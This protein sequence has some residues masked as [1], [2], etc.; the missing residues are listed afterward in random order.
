MIFAEKH[1]TTFLLKGF[2]G[3]RITYDPNIINDWTAIDAV[4]TWVCGVIVP[5]GLVIFQKRLTE[6]ENR[7]SASNLALLEELKEFKIKYEPILSSLTSGEVVMNAGNASFGIT[8]QTPS[9]SEI[10][11]YICI[12]MSASTLEIANHFNVTPADIKSEIE[13]LWAVQ[14]L[15]S[16]ATL[17]DD[18]RNGYESCNRTKSK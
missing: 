14:K 18:P 15:I 2:V 17:A 12:S 5:I 11:R 10:Y 3:F 7:T 13:D 1:H 9:S 16:P 8:T 6:S 4:G